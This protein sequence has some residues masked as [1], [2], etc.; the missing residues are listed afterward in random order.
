MKIYDKPREHIKKQ[1]HRF[2]NKGSYNQSYGFS[3][4][5]VQM[6]ELDHKEGWAP[7]N[8]CFQT[9][10]WEKTPGRP[11]DR[12]EIRPVHPKG[13]QPW[14]FIGR[15]DAE[16]TTCWPPDAKSRLIRKDWGRLKA[17]GEGT[18]ENEMLEGITDSV[19][20]SLSRRQERA[21]DREAWRAAV[22]GVS[23]SPTRFSNWATTTRKNL[24]FAKLCLRFKDFYVW[25]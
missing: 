11:L 22:H 2:P 10:V 18:A 13:D 14:L 21:K 4:S 9:V 20:M 5:H 8:W 1:R 6:W 7:K 3:S 19:D 23:K 12:K 25:S 15:S 16:A 17:K 24:Y